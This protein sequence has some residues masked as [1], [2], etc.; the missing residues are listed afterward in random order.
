MRYTIHRGSSETG[1]S[2]I[3][4]RSE[5]ARVLFD[6]GYPLFLNGQPILEPVLETDPQKLLEMGV[7]P[8]ISGLYQWDE[9]GFDAVVLSYAH[10]DHFGLL[11]WLHPDIPVWVSPGTRVLIDLSQRFKIYP[12]SVV[13]WQLF[14][15][16]RPFSINSMIIKPFLMDPSACDSAAFEIH[17][18]GQTVLYTG[19]FRGH[20]RKSKCLDNFVKQAAKDA[21]ALLIEGTM[22]GRADEAARTEDELE[23][24][25][26]SLMLEP[27]PFF[28]QCSNQNVD[29][30]V[31]FYNACRST[32]RIFV[33]D[34]YTASVLHALRKLGF[35]LPSPEVGSD[36]MHVFFPR[37]LTKQTVE[38]T[39][40]E[41]ARQFSRWHI[42]RAQ[43]LEQAD[44]IC[45]LVRPSMLPDLRKMTGLRF[46]QLVYSMHQGYRETQAQKRLEHL[47]RSR[48]TMI[49]PLHTN[50]HTR[51]R[52]LQQ[53]IDGLQPKCVV[54]VHGL[55]PERLSKMHGNVRIVQDGVEV[56]L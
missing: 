30:I 41:D 25:F 12:P 9:P 36:V 3:E 26:V 14:P 6:M 2:C 45:M 35:S 11:Q 8:R 4:I 29:R 18:D 28:F 16:H 31:T 43:I 47:M 52:D 19:D 39:G 51:I 48:G 1:G 24:E 27:G 17:A 56:M 42:S 21:D 44:R 55:Y 10:L 34:I 22:A 46:G 32:R 20:G 23:Q 40:E 37:R 15:L 5:S 53:V 54:P 7:L 33:I 49:V 38:E 50:G 13:E